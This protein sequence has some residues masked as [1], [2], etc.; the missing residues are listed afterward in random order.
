LT[1]LKSRPHQTRLLAWLLTF[2]ASSALAQFDESLPRRAFGGIQPV[3]S[4]DGRTIALSCQGAICRMP[5]DGAALI[6][7]SP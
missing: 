7:L 4:P 1:V 5:S 3:L 2:A 6:R